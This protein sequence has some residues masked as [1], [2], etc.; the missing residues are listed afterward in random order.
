MI[1]YPDASVDKSWIKYQPILRK[2]AHSIHKQSWL[3]NDSDSK[4]DAEFSGTSILPPFGDADIDSAHK[5]STSKY[6]L[7][8]M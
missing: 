3:A 8:F 2:Y 1:T 7:L 4:V 5:N 6:Y